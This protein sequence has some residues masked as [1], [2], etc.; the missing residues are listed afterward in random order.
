MPSYNVAAD[1]AIGLPSRILES[2]LEMAI[3]EK[4]HLSPAVQGHS[5]LKPDGEQSHSP[6]GS[7]GFN[8]C[9]GREH[10]STLDSDGEVR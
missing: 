10:R 1:S 5:G 6:S 3:D 2:D 9:C 7:D 4:S 8:E